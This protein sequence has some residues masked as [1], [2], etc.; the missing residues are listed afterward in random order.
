MLTEGQV[1][2]GLLGSIGQALF[3]EVRYDEEV[4]YDATGNPMTTTFLDYGMPSA[5]ELPGFDTAHR[6][7]PTP[8]NPLGANGPGEAGTTGLL[9]GSIRLSSTPSPTRACATCTFP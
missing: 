5:A 2:G 3:D 1:H 9:G 8:N 4:R 6:I 7:T